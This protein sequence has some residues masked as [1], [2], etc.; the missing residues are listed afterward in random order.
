MVV[1]R[2]YGKWESHG[3]NIGH[4]AS[5]DKEEFGNKQKLSSGCKKL[6]RKKFRWF[7]ETLS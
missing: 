1:M 7:K 6:R 5:R 4:K 2:D 3:R